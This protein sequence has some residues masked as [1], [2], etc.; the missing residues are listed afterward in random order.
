MVRPPF[1]KITYFRFVVNNIQLRKM[2]T[3]IVCLCE[4]EKKSKGYKR[5]SLS[6]NI[7]ST[8]TVKEGLERL[9]NLDLSESAKDFLCLH[10]FATLASAINKSKEA[11]FAEGQL[12]ER[13]HQGSVICHKRK[14]C[15]LTPLKPKSKRPRLF[16]PKHRTPLSVHKKGKHTPKV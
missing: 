8:C 2:S 15:V 1:P 4:I 11:C 16:T 7:S 9:Y 12:T 5:K 14:E 13:L 3:C 6:S 10:C